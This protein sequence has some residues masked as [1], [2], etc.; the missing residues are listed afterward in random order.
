M[1]V[2]DRLPSGVYEPIDEIDVGDVIRW[3][4]SR[5]L[6]V[7]RA[8]SRDVEDRVLFV[9]FAIL[10]PSW[11]NRPYTVYMRSDL[12]QHFHGIVSAK[13]PLCTTRL[14]CLTQKEIDRRDTHARFIHASET[15]GAVP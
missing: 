9:C 8:V 10:R 5:R 2:G 4:K 14:D 12:R 7:V 13:H 3:G 11:T 15:A 1:A 6:R